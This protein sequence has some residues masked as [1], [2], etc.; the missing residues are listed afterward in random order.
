MLSGF[1][2]YK[3]FSVCT[4]KAA[5]S[6]RI[7]TQAIVAKTLQMQNNKWFVEHKAAAKFN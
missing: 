3:F 7:D 6:D 5:T 4:M 1:R 2:L